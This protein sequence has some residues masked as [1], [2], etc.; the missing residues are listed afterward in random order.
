[1]INLIFPL[2]YSSILFFSLIA[3]CAYFIGQLKMTQKVEK[4]LTVLENRLQN[5][6]RTSESFYKLGQLYLRK[7]IYDKAI[8]LFRNSLKTWDK[9][10]KIG[11]G[12][13]YN[14]LGFT[15]FKL[16]Q[17][18]NAIY[19]YKQ[20]TK[21]LPDYALALTNLGLAYENKQM[22]KEALSTYNKVLDY[23]NNNN[24]ALGRLP[25]MKLK[26]TLKS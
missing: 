6:E 16:K 11:L 23:D 3:I 12:S 26:A 13:L 24:V 1:M 15:Y 10:D 14:T 9:N 8:N 17:Y 21:L 4:R 19:Y 25:I 2:A 18:D 22:Y 20:A 7:K 5:S